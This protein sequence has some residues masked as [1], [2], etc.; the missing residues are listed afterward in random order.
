MGPWGRT[1]RDLNINHGVLERPGRDRFAHPAA[2]A[3][4]IDR[5]DADGRKTP[6]QTPE[7]LFFQPSVP[8]INAENFVDGIAKEEA[9]VQGGNPNL[10]QRHDLAVQIR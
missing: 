8:F 7:M 1:A 6:F 5:R 10:G 3:A 9:T 4:E 2:Q